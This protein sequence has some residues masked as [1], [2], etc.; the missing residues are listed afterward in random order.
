MHENL[1]FTKS[2]HFT[3]PNLGASNLGNLN[4]LMLP[5]LS[6]IYHSRNHHPNPCLSHQLA[7]KLLETKR[8]SFEVKLYQIEAE[9]LL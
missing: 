3:K 8:Y 2:S 9:F 4:F 7:A 1:R 5:I 6:T